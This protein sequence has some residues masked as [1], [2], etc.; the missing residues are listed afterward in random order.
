MCPPLSASGKEGYKNS[1]QESEGEGD[2]YRPKLRADGGRKMAGGGLRML[3]H[4]V[5]F[6]A[7]VVGGA[8]YLS[9]MLSTQ[10]EV[11]DK[12]SPRLSLSSL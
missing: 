3:S 10:I 6:V 1:R 5:P 12:V 4:G 8:Y 9:T 11:R 2:T 7:V